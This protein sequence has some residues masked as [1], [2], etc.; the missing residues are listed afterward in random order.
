MAICGF[1][2]SYMLL[3]AEHHLS[4]CHILLCRGSLA[5]GLVAR[6]RYSTIMTSGCPCTWL[7]LILSFFCL[8]N[9]DLSKELYAI[10]D[11][12]LITC[13]FISFQSFP[14]TTAVFCSIPGI[15]ILV[16][17]YYKQEAPCCICVVSLESAFLNL[18]VCIS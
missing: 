17:F 5:L 13:I 12:L 11:N 3:L 2:G 16:I 8:Y 6:Q 1:R 9:F 14:E 10:Q 15:F 4:I 7:I 18:L